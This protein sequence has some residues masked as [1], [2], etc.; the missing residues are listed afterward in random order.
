MAASHMP[1]VPSCLRQ[2]ALRPS[3]GERSLVW[4]CILV[5]CLL[6][7]CTPLARTWC[8][9]LLSPGAEGKLG[10]PLPWKG[11]GNTEPLSLPQALVP[12][13]PCMSWLIYW[14]NLMGHHVQIKHY[15]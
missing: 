11:L 8:S 3:G 10:R 9:T 12:A 5:G 6:H 7:V 1:L 2:D 4:F 15:F 13:T 14:A